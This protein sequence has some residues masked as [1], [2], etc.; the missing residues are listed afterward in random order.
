M[1]CGDQMLIYDGMHSVMK[2]KQWSPENP[3]YLQDYRLERKH[4]LSDGFVEQNKMQQMCLKCYKVC[5]VIKG[6]AQEAGLDFDETFA[7]VVQI[8]SVH[9]YY[10]GI[11]FPY[12]WEGKSFPHLRRK[13]NSALTTGMRFHMTKEITFH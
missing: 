6:F 12:R 7:P 5:I 10:H 2:S 3:G 13:W 8:D 1:L 9:T 4:Y 11:L